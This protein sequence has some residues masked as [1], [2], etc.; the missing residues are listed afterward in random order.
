MNC[1]GVVASFETRPFGAFLS[2]RLN[3][4]GTT[5]NLMLRRP[6]S[7]RLEARK[8]GDPAFIHS[9]SVKPDGLEAERR[10]GRGPYAVGGGQR[11]HRPS[12]SSRTT[13]S[14]GIGSRGIA[15][16]NAACDG[17]LL[18]RRV[19]KLRGVGLPL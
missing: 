11:R 12:L 16:R 14:L 9:L 6:R 19:G 5:K 15:A 2:M 3:L 17:I 8:S 1:I 18:G 10:G 7:D 13:P 4:C